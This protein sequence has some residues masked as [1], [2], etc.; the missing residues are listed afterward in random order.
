MFIKFQ[1]STVG[2]GQ[3][4]RLSE[5]KGPKGMGMMGIMGGGAMKQRISPGI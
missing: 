2:R 4:Q 1:S 3:L 5:P